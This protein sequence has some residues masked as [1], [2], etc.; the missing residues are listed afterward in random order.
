[1]P[2]SAAPRNVPCTATL[3]GMKWVASTPFTVSTADQ[4]RDGNEINI[5][6]ST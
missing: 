2:R 1:M 5:A 3:Y 6:K 4:R